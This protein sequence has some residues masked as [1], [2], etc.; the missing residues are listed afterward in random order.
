MKSN[1]WKQMSNNILA[2]SNYLGL[3]TGSLLTRYVSLLKSLKLTDFLSLS[4]SK[5][6]PYLT[7]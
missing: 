1:L 4:L 6:D 7:G 5:G 3:H 2:A